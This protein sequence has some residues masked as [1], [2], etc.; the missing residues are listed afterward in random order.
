MLPGASVVPCDAPSAAGEHDRPATLPRAPATGPHAWS[1]GRRDIRLALRRNP[2][3]GIVA[4]LT[5][6]LS[7]TLSS[8]ALQPRLRHIKRCLRQRDFAGVFGD[9]EN[10]AVYVARYVPTRALCYY[11]LLS[12]EPRLA[13]ILRP[14]SGPVV[15]A[16]GAAAPVFCIGSGPGSELIALACQAALAHP[17]PCSLNVVCQDVADWAPLLQQL[18]DALAAQWGVQ[19]GPAGAQVRFCRGDAMD[20]LANPTP[21]L[22]AL[23]HSAALVM[24]MFVVNELLVLKGRAL[25]LFGA[26]IR[27]MR[28]G[29]HL[30]VL[31]S[32]SDLSVVHI[33]QSD[34]WVHYVLDGIAS[35]RRVAGDNS[36]WYRVP[37]AL[38]Y[39]LDIQNVRYYWR[40]YRTPVSAAPDDSPAA[41]PLD[42]VA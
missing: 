11:D 23:V 17:A 32:A 39:P 37:P 4:L 35:L 33:G 31:D 12:R 19:C 9:A 15:R 7:S 29:A 1:A 5:T 38:T 25:A 40:L 24:L 13:D 2:A 8:A 41:L 3:Q 36:R 20:L 16:A 30:L 26:L 27:L 21:E 18:S 22:A 10:H 34:Y 6:V 42:A 28:P 14:C